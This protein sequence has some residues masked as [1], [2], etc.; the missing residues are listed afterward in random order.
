MVFAGYEI[1]Q[2]H[3]PDAND[4][5][6]AHLDSIR[7]VG[8]GFYPP[9]VVEDWGEGLTADVYAKAMEGGEVFFIAIGPI[10]NERAVLGFATYRIDDARDGMSVYVR[11]VATR[12][13]IGS[14][15]LKSVEAHATAK[16]A[17]SIQVEASL[18]GVEFSK[19]NG[20]EEVGRGD[21]R[22]MSGR[23]IACVFMRKTLVT[24]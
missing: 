17:T 8:P 14:A 2:A 24:A 19:A 15:L 21:T 16:G 3:P 1:R 22:L 4:I 10:D 18:A 23:P 11:G 9:T 20:F 13:G 7:S 5:A 6:I 12:R